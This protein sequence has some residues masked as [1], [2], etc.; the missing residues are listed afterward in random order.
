MVKTSNLTSLC[1]AAGIAISSNG[2]AYYREQ[3]RVWSKPEP[4][5]MSLTDGP[6]SIQR[7]FELDVMEWN[8]SR[9]TRVRPSVW[10]DPDWY[11]KPNRSQFRRY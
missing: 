10:V 9:R 2:C 11:R 1:L 7:S 4:A 3:R 5:P 8:W 6:P